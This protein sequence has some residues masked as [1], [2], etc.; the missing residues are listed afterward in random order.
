[1]EYT[2]TILWTNEEPAHLEACENQDEGLPCICFELLDA[3]ED[4]ENNARI[5]D[6][7]LEGVKL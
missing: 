6:M 3:Q 2:D 5:D 7:L 1:M 4:S